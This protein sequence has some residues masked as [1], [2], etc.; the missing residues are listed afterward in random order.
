[1][2]RKIST[3]TLLALSFSSLL[4]SACGSAAEADAD[5]DVE[6]ESVGSS[7]SALTGQDRLTACAKDPRVV[8]GLVSARICAG[9]DIFARETFGGNGRTCTS[10]HPIGHNTTLDGPFVNALFAQNPN[11]PLFVFMNDPA[12]AGLE[13]QNGLFSFGNVLE[14]V[15][16]FEDPTHKFIL[17]SV[18]H[19]LGLSQTISADPTDPKA[20]VPPGERTGWGGDGAPGDGSLRAFLQGAIKQHYTKTLTREVGV[21]FREATPLELDLTNEFQRSLGRT[22]EL[23]L[24]QVNLSD[25]IANL[26][27]QVFLDPNKGRCNFCHLNAGANFQ[28]TGK[29]RNF[30]TEIRT[31]PA[32]GDIGVLADGTPVFDGGFGGINLAQPNMAGLSADP[33]VGDKNAFGNGTFN[34]PSLIEAADTGPFFHNHASFLGSEIE[35]AVFF[36]I[37]PSGFGRSEAAK[38]MLPRFP[39]PIAFTPD[40]GNAIGR[41]LRALNVAFNL[42]LAK[43]RLSAARTLFT[44]SGASSAAIQVGLLRLAD[45]ELN[46]ALT[47]LS[48]APV[49]PFYPVSVDQIGLART[50][51]ANAIAAP[52]SSRG[53]SISNAVSRVETARS[54]IGANINYNLGSGNLLF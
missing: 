24:N 38:D 7:S 37:D 52:A 3:L 15:D 5:P 45:A 40:E 25:P 8:A 27:R 49:Q 19:T 16:G 1:M 42:D 53:G 36:Y 28:D 13:S 4:A 2:F 54:P 39:S 11:D 47:V 21:D 12:L 14:N 18:P 30:D 34:T 33:N 29:G 23:D 32:V 6:L 41:F 10:C 22:R 31:S 43:Q 17:R 50:E 46:D 48:H 51:I 20:T 35:N 44:R 26:G 9:G